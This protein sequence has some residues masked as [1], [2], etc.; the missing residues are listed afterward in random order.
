MLAVRE[1]LE[2]DSQTGQVE[3]IVATAVMFLRGVLP[4]ADMGK[5]RPAG[6]IRPAGDFILA[7][8]HL[9]KLKLPP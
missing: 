7:R 9:H 2:F 1:L 6:Q 4:R 8:R 3:H 5:L